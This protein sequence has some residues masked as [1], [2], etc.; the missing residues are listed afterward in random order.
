MNNSHAVSVERPG[1][2]PDDHTQTAAVDTQT[3]LR[4][5]DRKVLQVLVARFGPTRGGD[6]HALA[7]EY[8]WRR[9]ERVQAMRYPIAYLVRVGTSASRNR[10]KALPESD[11]PN[12]PVSGDWDFEPGLRA[13]LLR[14]PRRQREIVLLVEGCGWTQQEVAE[15][16]RVSPSTVHTQLRRGMARLRT[17]LGVV[18]DES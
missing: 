3:F 12:V 18:P 1:P 13:A 16:L 17:E 9:C 8:A 15:T 10:R 11:V 4:S 7:M 5:I 6:A 2:L 14:L